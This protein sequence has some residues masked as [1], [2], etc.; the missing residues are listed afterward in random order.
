[1]PHHPARPPNEERDIDEPRVRG[2]AAEA[3]PRE[4]CARAEDRHADGN[5]R[6]DD[7]DLGLPHRHRGEAGEHRVCK[8][9]GRQAVDEA[10][11]DVDVERDTRAHEVDARRRSRPREPRLLS[12]GFLKIDFGIQADCLLA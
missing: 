3:T 11:F 12:R 1:V 8:S 5:A 7:H 6:G 9:K 4:R 2:A 10:V